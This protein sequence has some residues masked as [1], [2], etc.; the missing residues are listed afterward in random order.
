MM[1]QIGNPVGPKR[2]SRLGI[3]SVIIGA[4]L[5]FLLI[6][7]AVLGVALG[8]GKKS[9]GSYFGLGFVFLGL[10]GPLI[11]L[12]G[13]GLGVG[14]LISKKTKKFFPVTGAILNAL[15]GISGVLIIYFIIMNL[16]WGFH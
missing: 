11:H 15:L 12:I 5:P 14:G 13:L 1:E 4:T 3:A 8:T 16:T 6:A 7:L 2:H 10:A 9:I